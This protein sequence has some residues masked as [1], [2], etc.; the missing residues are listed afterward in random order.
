MAFSMTV[1]PR[2]DYAS[3]GLLDMRTVGWSDADKNYMYIY[4]VINRTY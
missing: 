4:G 2:V 1:N 3:S